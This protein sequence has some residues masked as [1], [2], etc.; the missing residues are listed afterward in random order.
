MAF[1]ALCNFVLKSEE[2]PN[3]IHK[4]C[5]LTFKE[6]LTHQ[7]TALPVGSNYYLLSGLV[8]SQPWTFLFAVLSFFALPFPFVIHIY[9]CMFFPWVSQS[10]ERLHRICMYFDS[11][12]CYCPSLMHITAAL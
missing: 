2:S 1:Y 7:L 9:V 10:G 6:C 3:K 11:V 12:C 5:N 4:A 8:N